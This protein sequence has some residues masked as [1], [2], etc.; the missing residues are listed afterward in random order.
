MT[1]TD[2]ITPQIDR[3]A[4]ILQS[5]Y[6]GYNPYAC[7]VACTNNPSCSSFNMDACGS[8]NYV[9]NLGSGTP[10][11][12]KFL[13]TCRV[14]GLKRTSVALQPYTISGISNHHL[15]SVLIYVILIF[16]II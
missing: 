7:L 4:T 1:G 9:C 13:G 16:V 8:Q 11:S 10:S 15:V 12:T 6:L 3:P 2:S 14:S 5:L